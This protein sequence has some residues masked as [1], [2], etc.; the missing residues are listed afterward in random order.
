MGDLIVKEPEGSGSDFELVEAGNYHAICYRYYDLGKQR[1]EFE[2]KSKDVHRVLITWELPEERIEIDV[3]DLPRVISK[4]YTLSLHENATLRQHLETW[5]G[6]KFSKEE[7]KA[8]SLLN[9]LGKNCMINVIHNTRNDKTY[10]NVGSIAPLMKGMAKREAENPI[11]SFS[12]VNDGF[13]NI[14]EGTSEKVIAKI[15]NSLEYEA[16]SDD[17]SDGGDPNQGPA[18]DEQNPPPPDDDIPF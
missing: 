18:Y 16:W 12:I 15:Q 5:R 11:V 3:Q 6:R 17:K 2:G 7:L 8:F 1:L 9:I 14:P 13:N 4:E 10:A